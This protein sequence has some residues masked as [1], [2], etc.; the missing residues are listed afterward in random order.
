[1]NKIVTI[2]PHV[3]AAPIDAAPREPYPIGALGDI[4]APAALLHSRRR[5]G[6]RSEMAAQSVLER[7]QPR[8]TSPRRR[9][10]PR[11]GQTL[12]PPS[13]HHRREF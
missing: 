1:M 7:R 8:G 2:T 4:L 6:A 12:E 9:P 3:S 10:D 13:P 5:S 11:L